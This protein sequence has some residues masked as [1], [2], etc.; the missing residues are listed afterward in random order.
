MASHQESY[1][2]YR[3]PSQN[4]PSQ[5]S[6]VEQEFARAIDR[7]A[8]HPPSDPVP[9]SPEHPPT[10]PVAAPPAT[11]NDATADEP[12]VELP[13]DGT[14]LLHVIREPIEWLLALAHRLAGEDAIDIAAIARLRAALLARLAGQPVRIRKT[15]VLIVFGLL[16]GALDPS[17]IARA[18]SNT[19]GDGFVAVLGAEASLGIHLTGAPNPMADLFAALRLQCSG[20]RRKRRPLRP[21]AVR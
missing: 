19:I 21:Y 14:D 2:Q 18:V 12:T 13:V 20:E 1:V 9:A 6:S 3:N 11:G 10:D 5:S 8:E 7:F 17:A 16:A 15:D 4:H